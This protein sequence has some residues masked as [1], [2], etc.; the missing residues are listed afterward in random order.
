MLEVSWKQYA[1]DTLLAYLA[2]IQGLHAQLLL[3]RVNDPLLLVYQGT[4]LVSQLRQ[5]LG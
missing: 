3:E 1:G 2:I 5:A 4:E